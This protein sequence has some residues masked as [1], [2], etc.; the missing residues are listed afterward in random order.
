MLKDAILNYLHY[1]KAFALSEDI[2]ILIDK[3][4]AEVKAKLSPKFCF[5]IVDLSIKDKI[6]LLDLDISH[7]AY[8]TYLAGSSKLLLIAATLGVQ[9]DKLLLYY[10][11]IDVS[12]MLLLDA[13]MNAYLEELMDDYCQKV[14]P[15]DNYR[16]A[17]GYQG[18]DVA[19]IKDIARHL[20]ATKKIGINILESNLIVPQKSMINIVGDCKKKASCKNCLINGNCSF[21]ERKQLCYKR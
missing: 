1:N 19:I 21:I 4:I 15:Y 18:T 20:D 10:N 17:P 3:A 5:E 11:K 2:N 12:Y 8:Q 9:A 7:S 14:F 13:T 6:S 16:F